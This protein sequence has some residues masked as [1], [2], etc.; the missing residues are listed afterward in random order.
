MELQAVKDPQNADTFVIDFGAAF[1]RYI[2]SIQKVWKHDRSTTLGGSEVFNC[3]RQL[4]FEKRHKEWGIEPDPDFEQSWGA[5]QRGNIIEDHYVVP[6]LRV[7]L[8]PT[9]LVLEF[10]GS[11]QETL[12]KGRNSATP[13]GV[14]C[15]VPTDRDVI[16]KYRDKVI[17]IGR[18]PSGCIGLEIKS[19]DPRATLEEEK[20]KH[21][22]QSQVGMGLI[23]EL[24]QW[25]PDHWIILYIDA[26][27][28]DNITPFVV[29][30][31]P[32]IFSAAQKR[33]EVVWAAKNPMDLMPEGKL[34][35][36]CDSC[37]WRV[38]C[39][40]AVLSAYA[41]TNQ[42]PA[43]PFEIAEFDPL[44]V[45]YLALKDAKDD[46]EKRFKE[47]GQKIKDRLLDRKKNKIKSD[48]WGITW[49]T[50]KGKKTYDT[51]AMQDDGIDLSAYEREGLPF[52]KL[53]VTPK[54]G[55]SSDE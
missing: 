35:K 20:A 22:G 49:S 23:R 44:V 24:T 28:I 19:I 14:I 8:E 41:K 48:A 5:M 45:E 43:D 46:A 9:G 42:Q 31:D 3:I 50:V 2:E 21:H 6:A 17:S 40:E 13:D 16:V 37:R 4:G 53:V 38:A 34:D 10:A 18:V 15:D 32:A 1:D 47:I 36:G 7:G 27:F 33:A 55:R 51:K 52:D 30:F 54:K 12:V 39:T 11:D 29:H 26:S 25:K